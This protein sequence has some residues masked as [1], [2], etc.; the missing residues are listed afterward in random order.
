MFLGVLSTILMIWN[1]FGEL[2]A[3]NFLSLVFSCKP[4]VTPG[5]GSFNIENGEYPI[6]TMISSQVRT[7]YR[8]DN[9]LVTPVEF[10]ATPCLLTSEKAW[11]KN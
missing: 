1:Y 7:D 5:H 3:M 8:R 6:K 11:F 4:D 9:L 10:L 2:W